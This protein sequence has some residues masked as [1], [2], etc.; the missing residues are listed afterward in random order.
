MSE[1]VLRARPIDYARLLRVSNAPTA[2]ADVWMGC[3]VATGSLT[4][5][6]PLAIFSLGSLCLYHGG[7]S[8]NDAVD[9]EQDAAEGRPRPIPLGA[10]NRR[11][12]YT[13]AYALLGAGLGLAGLGSWLVGSVAG[14]LIAIA[15]TL[16]VVNYNSSVKRSP[17][18]PVLMGMCRSMNLG[19]GIAVAGAAQ[20]EAAGAAAQ[21]TSPGVFFYVMGITWFATDEAIG[22]RRSR[23]ATGLCLSALG[24]A[25]LALCPLWIPAP[26]VIAGNDTWTMLWMVAALFSLRGMVVGVLQPSPKS[27]GR[28]VGLA[29]QG[30]V[31][32]NA[33]LATLYAGPQPG[34]AILALL[35]VTMLLARSIP[36]T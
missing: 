18:G 36:Q 6:W 10:I 17:V 32:V 29:I 9:A 30:L 7:M 2:V 25:W 26:R 23:L 20:A 13:I 16:F 4:P 14:L 11:A 33:T 22:G 5:S 1:A 31:L 3:A 24:I 15:I 28:G 19:L 8:L 27:V 21:C 12:A 34:L 35:P